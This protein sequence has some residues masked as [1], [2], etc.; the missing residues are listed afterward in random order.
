MRGA[1][2]PLPCWPA[3]WIGAC[4]MPGRRYCSMTRRWSKPKARVALSSVAPA[5]Y[6]GP[7]RVSASGIKKALRL[8]DDGLLLHSLDTL[9]AKLA[10]RF[11]NTCR[12][13][14]DPT[15]P[16]LSQ[17]TEPTDADSTPRRTS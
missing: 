14:A 17:L 8:T 13:P 5:A 16:A 11:R 9:I 4:T 15:V 6:S 10:M 1:S 2:V 7:S 12:A 3:I